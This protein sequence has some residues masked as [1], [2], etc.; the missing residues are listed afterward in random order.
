MALEKKY[1]VFLAKM[2]CAGKN[3]KKRSLA[4][5][6]ELSVEE[7]NEIWPGWT[8]KDIADSF[9]DIYNHILKAEAKGVK[10]E[11]ARLYTRSLLAESWMTKQLTVWMTDGTLSDAEKERL[12]QPLF[13]VNMAW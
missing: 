3:K 4:S 8:P 12:E 13:D 10:R 9:L 11:N 5:I 6:N 2:E 7:L 1:I